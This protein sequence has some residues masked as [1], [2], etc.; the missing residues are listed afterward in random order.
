MLMARRFD[1]LTESVMSGRRRCS[2]RPRCLLTAGRRHEAIGRG[3]R[4]RSHTLGGI[5]A[6]IMAAARGS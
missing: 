3:R 5:T 6:S 4:P 2:C 1:A